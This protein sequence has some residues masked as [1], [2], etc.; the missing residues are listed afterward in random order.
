MTTEAP[1]RQR[2]VDA[3]ASLFHRSGYHAVGVNDLCRAA[4]VRKG[5]FYHFF[6]SKEALALAAIEHQRNGTIRD[7]LEPCF[8]DDVPPADRIRRYFDVLAEFNDSQMGEIDVFLGCPFGNM[9]AEIGNGEEL[10]AG[11]V[12]QA[13]ATI[14]DYFE[15]CLADARADGADIDVALGA[16]A[17]LAFMEGVVLIARSRRDPDE[18]RRLGGLAPRVAGL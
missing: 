6:E 1:P 18:I 9:S 8:A 5:S 14:R 13:L 4:D 7:V 3:A 16:D 12:T 17:L 11:A 2:L 10:I 15:A